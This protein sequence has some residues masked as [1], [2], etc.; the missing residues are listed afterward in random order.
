MT[1]RVKREAAFATIYAVITESARTRIGRVELIAGATGKKLSANSLFVAEAGLLVDTGADEERLRA[2]APRVAR[3]LYTHY[4]GDHR[5]HSA[6]FDGVETWAHALDAPPL[7]SIDA[8]IDSVVID[9]DARDGFGMWF[10][11]HV[12]EIRVDRT[13]DTEDVVDLGGVAVAPLHLPGHTPGLLCPYFP[14]ERLLFLTDYDLTRFGPWYGNVGSDLDA[15]EA[16]LARIAG[17]DADWFMT[18][19]LPG[20]LTR[21]EMLALL[22]PYREQIPKRDERIVDLLAEP[23]TITALS[24]IGICYRKAHLRREPQLLW[25]ERLQLEHHLRRLAKHGA[26][27]QDG[28]R[29]RRK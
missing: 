22:E 23:M 12:S 2:L 4:H 15:F 19:H 27:I 21:E 13:V 24:E 6:L 8:M 14:E 18:S 29:W 26:V 16:S 9:A 3:V 5:W 25:F 11:S 10:R 28:D 20:A 1:W 17:F 7:R